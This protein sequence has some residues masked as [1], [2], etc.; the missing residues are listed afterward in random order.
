MNI[1]TAKDIGNHIGQ[2]LE[3]DAEQDGTT[4]GK[5]LTVWI[6]VDINKPLMGAWNLY[7]EGKNG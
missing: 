5:F 7:L 2:F 1:E 6:D 3:V 4:W